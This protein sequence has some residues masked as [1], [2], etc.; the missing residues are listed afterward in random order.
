MDANLQRRFLCFRGCW[1]CL[2]PYWWSLWVSRNAHLTTLSP[3]PMQKVKR[4]ASCIAEKIIWRAWVV[5][6]YPGCWL[7]GRCHP[8]HLLVSATWCGH[9]AWQSPSLAESKVSVGIRWLHHF[10]L[11]VLITTNSGLHAFWIYCELRGVKSRWCKDDLAVLVR[12][13]LPGRVSS[14]VHT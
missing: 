7:I 9:K 14:D 3:W 1:F 11:L 2:G 13:I 6:L 4:A 8:S 5:M 12:L 10:V